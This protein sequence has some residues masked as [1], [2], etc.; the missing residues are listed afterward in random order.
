VKSRRGR[1]AVTG[2][3]V[4]ELLDPGRLIETPLSPPA[5]GTRREGRS[6]WS[7]APD[8]EPEDLPQSLVWRCPRVMGMSAAAS[9]IAHGRS[10]HV[11]RN[12]PCMSEGW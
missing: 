2:L 3:P 7:H 9:G 10:R 5:K 11:L 8:P 6:G 1:A 12:V 4:I